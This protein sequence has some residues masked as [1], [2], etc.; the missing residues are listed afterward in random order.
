MTM[1]TKG[2][3]AQGSRQVAQWFGTSSKSAFACRSRC[4]GHRSGKC[5]RARPYP[6]SQDAWTIEIATG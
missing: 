1:T 5:R 2:T 3:N 4:G 6:I